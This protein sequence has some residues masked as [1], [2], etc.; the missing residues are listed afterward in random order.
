M[1]FVGNMFGGGGG[2]GNSGQADID[3]SQNQAINQLGQLL[4]Q[5]NQVTNT[6]T[7]Q[8]SEINHQVTGLTHQ[9]NN[10]TNI[11]QDHDAKI[12]LIGNVLEHEDTRISN[13]EGKIATQGQINEAQ[14][15]LNK[16]IVGTIVDHGNQINENTQAIGHHGDDLLALKHEVFPH[17][18]HTMGVG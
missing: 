10:L 7:Q 15:N 13:I 16:V 18:Y 5:Q 2:G 8:I 12:N 14:G 4:S 1:S 3:S 17:D 6:H 9:T 11:T